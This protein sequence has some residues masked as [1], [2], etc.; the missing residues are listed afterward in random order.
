[1]IAVAIALVLHD[2]RHA[3][4]VGAL[5]ERLANRAERSCAEAP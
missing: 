4:R 3:I 1:M 5:A 2:E